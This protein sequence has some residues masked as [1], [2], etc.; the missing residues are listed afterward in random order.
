MAYLLLCITIYLT[1]FISSI[2]MTVAAYISKYGFHMQRSNHKTPVKM[3]QNAKRH[4]RAD[5]KSKSKMHPAFKA[6]TPSAQPRKEEEQSK[7]TSQRVR[8]HHA[9]SMFR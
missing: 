6:S 9:K 3:Q 8:A 4:D 1:A 7:F 2:L 5:G